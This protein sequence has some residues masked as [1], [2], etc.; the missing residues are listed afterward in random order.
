MPASVTFF[1]TY[2]FLFSAFARWSTSTPLKRADCPGYKASNVQQTD[3]S[4]TAD[5]TLAGTACNIYGKDLTDLKFLAEYQTGILPDSLHPVVLVVPCPLDMYLGVWQK[6]RHSRGLHTMLQ[7]RTN[8]GYALQTN[9]PRLSRAGTSVYSTT[10]VAMNI[11]TAHGGQ[12]QSRTVAK[13]FGEL[14]LASLDM[15][16]VLLQY[17]LL[18]A[19][20]PGFA[21]R[22]S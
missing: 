21:R 17:K 1:Q 19:G 6:Y 10:L 18:L 20:S 7:S 15:L 12:F 11:P 16:L 2:L 3:S 14:Y 13:G 22:E 5:L 4:V 8:I 9:I